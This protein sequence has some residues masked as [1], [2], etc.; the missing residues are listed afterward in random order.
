LYGNCTERV[1]QRLM[2]TKLSTSLDRK[3]F[4]RLV[5][6]ALRQLYDS[7]FLDNNPLGKI[8]IPP[9][10]RTSQPAQDLRRVLLSV[11][12]DLRPQKNVPTQ[13]HDWRGY[14]ILEMRYISGMDAAEVMRRLGLGHT[15]YFTEQT[16]I[17]Q[18]LTDVLW[19]LR[20]RQAIDVNDY[21]HSIQVQSETNLSQGVN[22][23]I[24]R[25]FQEASWEVVN[26]IELL[27]DLRPVIQ[28]QAQI[29][30]V[31][32][33]Y[34]LVQAVVVNRA[35]RVLLRQIF[36]NLI[37]EVLE[38]AK[39]GRLSVESFDHQ[40]TFGIFLRGRT[41]QIDA[42]SS[43]QGQRERI[44]KETYRQLIEAMQGE[45]QFELKGNESYELRLSWNKVSQRAQVLL[46]IDD[47]TDMVDLFRRY[48]TGLD[49][50]VRGAKNIEEARQVMAEKL[51]T[52]IILDVILPQL[53]G[54]ELLLSLKSDPI[55]RE[56]P[57]VVCSAL[58]EP[59]L[60]KSLGADYFLPK[61]VDQLDLL[62]I[63]RL[64][65]TTSPE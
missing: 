55:T 48:L 22:A 16:R 9:E 13:S 49:L 43:L 40:T 10:K 21:P 20:L 38:K 63:L 59:E 32:L 3:E 4:D 64:Q 19:N 26:V 8:L 18:T 29:A 60:A 6:E 50:Q 45:V 52:L 53:D 46:V 56:I 57:I 61:P 12:R 51:P 33:S 44:S 58:N 28:S 11:I 62:A 25:L 42:T 23:E 36:L 15:L 31:D 24:M 37:A 27:D 1:R 65:G 5:R 35:N 17:L 2:T 39:D 34:D 47:N 41:S 30:Q 7:T 54:W 14:Q